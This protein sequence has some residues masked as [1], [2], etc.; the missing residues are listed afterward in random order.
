VGI[1]SVFKAKQMTG[2]RSAATVAM[3]RRAIED[4]TCLS[5]FH[6]EFRVRFAP[7]ALGRDGNGRRSVFAFEYG[8]MTLGQPHWVCF[9]VDRLRRLQRIGDRWRSGSLESRPQFDLGEIEAAVDDSWV[10]NL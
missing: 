4:R 1:I 2:E 9:V 8:G 6:V 7:H 5:G 10:R 3:I